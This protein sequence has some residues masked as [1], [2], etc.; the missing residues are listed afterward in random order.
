LF[1][2]KS[3][4]DPESHSCYH[5]RYILIGHLNSPIERAINIKFNVS[6]SSMMWST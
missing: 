3:L 6:R 4:T 5:V 1:F 2:A